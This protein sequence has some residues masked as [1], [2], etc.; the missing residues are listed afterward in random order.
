MFLQEFDLSQLHRGLD[1]RP[2][3]LCTDVLPV[4]Q[5][6]PRYRLQFQ[7][8]EEIGEFIKDVSDVKIL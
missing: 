7:A 8:N 4:V 2:D 6:A 1:S 3:V 5:G